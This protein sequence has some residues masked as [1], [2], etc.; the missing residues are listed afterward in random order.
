MIL[1]LDRWSVPLFA[2]AALAGLGSVSTSCGADAP[3][4]E[5]AKFFEGQV[6]PVLKANCFS[7]HGGEKK[8]KGGLNLTSRD[9]L[10][11][12]GD[13][14]PAV[15][16]AKPRD[17]LLVKAIHYDELEMPPKGK[18]PQSQIDTLTRWVEMGLPWSVG[19]AKVARH[20]PP[21][22]DVESKNWWSFR[23]VQR[24]AVPAV[25]NAAWVTNPI[26][27]FVRAKLEA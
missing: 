22:V 3:T 1:R 23:P 24:P 11:K 2:A 25:K 8:I 4:A 19:E 17:S 27:A 7:C 6:L 10:L 16:L 20:G 9:G 26:D 21:K 18:L 5:Q 12:G 13:T 14:G 15:D